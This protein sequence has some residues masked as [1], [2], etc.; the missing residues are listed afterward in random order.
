MFSE[1]ESVGGDGSPISPILRSM[2]F[3]SFDS[4]HH[5]SK[6]VVEM[7]KVIAHDNYAKGRAVADACTLAQFRSLGRPPCALPPE[8]FRML[9][10]AW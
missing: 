1:S 7:V 8:R 6:A 4:R 3:R 2:E 5:W 9:A 10:A